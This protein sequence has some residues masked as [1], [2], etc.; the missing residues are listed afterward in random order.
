L[1]NFVYLFGFLFFTSTAFAQEKNIA[2]IV[3]DKETKFRL[4]RVKIINLQTKQT[5]FNSAKGEFYINAK[6]GDVLICNLMGYQTDS[7]KITN[8]ETLI[9]YLKRLSIRLQEVVV[10]DSVLS[11]KAKYEEV[12]KDFNK[13]Y[14]LGNNKDL[15]TV[16]QGGAGLGIDAIWS[17]FSKEGRNARR[18]LELM[19]RDYQNNFVD[20]IFTRELVS[21]TTGLTGDK[22]LIFM[23]NNRPS[24]IFISK[25]SSYDLVNYIRLSFMRY[26]VY[27]NYQDVSGLKPIE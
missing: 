22:L 10:K 17:A 20:Q 23:L 18:L 8:Q 9:F 21:R 16:G 11:A 2:G 24:Y 1:R 13:L 4:S 25:A 12:K 19:E 7:L 6:P 14:R 3:F 26:N 15:I 5:V 27:V